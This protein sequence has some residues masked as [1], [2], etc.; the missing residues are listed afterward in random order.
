MRRTPFSFRLSAAL[1]A[2]CLASFACAQMEKLQDL[3]TF[4]RGTL[5]IRHGKDNAHQF[6]V[7]IA[8]TP[9]RQSQGLMFVRDLPADEGMVFLHS[10]PRAASMWMKNTYIPLDMLFVDPDGRI[11]KIA[12]QT[13]PHS[14]EPIGT[15]TAV[16]A[17]IEL[18]GGEASRRG[19]KVGDRASWTL[20]PR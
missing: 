15:N 12:E 10:P 8:D 2:L 4:P 3:A 5:E 19:L 14:L 20:Q 6:K 13:T 11:V 1:L 9:A 7:W 17:V 16:G 18:R